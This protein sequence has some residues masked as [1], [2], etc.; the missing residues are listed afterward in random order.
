MFISLTNCTINSLVYI[1]TQFIYDTVGNIQ[2]ENELLHI[3][4]LRRVLDSSHDPRGISL[5]L[6]TILV[7]LL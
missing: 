5:Q 6:L 7:V 2:Y 1:E 3:L 4:Y